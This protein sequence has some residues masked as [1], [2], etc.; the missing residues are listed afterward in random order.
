MAVGESG[1]SWQLREVPGRMS[2]QEEC[3]RRPK[4]SAGKDLDRSDSSQ[5]AV[6]I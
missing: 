1:Q 4:S 2:S 5:W 6:C 3:A